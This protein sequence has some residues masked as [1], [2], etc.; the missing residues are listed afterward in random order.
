[1]AQVD[2]LLACVDEKCKAEFD[3][4]DQGGAGELGLLYLCLIEK[5]SSPAAVCIGGEGTGDCGEALYCMSACSPLDQG[6]TVPCLQATSEEQSQK[7]GKFLQ[8][9]FETCTLQT[10][11]VCDIPT[12]CVLKCP[13][14]AG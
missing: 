4:F 1:M 3:A 11:P 10:L 8:C 7:T 14:L 6:C 9:V 13:E 5:C 12:S 2:A